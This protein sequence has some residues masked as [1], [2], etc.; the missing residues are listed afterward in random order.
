MYIVFEMNWIKKIFGKKEEPAVWENL[1]DETSNDNKP[2]PGRHPENVGDFYVENESCITCG[3]PEAEAPDLIVHSNKDNYGHCYFKKQPETEHELDQA[4]NAIC[5]SCIGALRYGGKD[6]SIIKRLYQIG[7]GDQCD[8]KPEEK[9]NIL[10]RNTAIFNYSGNLKDLAGLLSKLL[11]ETYSSF[12]LIEDVQ[13]EN[14]HKLV[15]T[16]AEGVEPLQIN[17][18]KIDTANF[19]LTFERPG[20]KVD[21]SIVLFGGVIHDRFK[22]EEDVTDLKWYEYQNPN[23]EYLKPY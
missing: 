2:I 9:W 10:I 22:K 1:S 8:T 14:K 5:V 21:E 19:K 20:N 13:K 4:I 7:E 11:K 23:T 17:L 18:S 16:W 15:F 3:A 6:Q 12:I